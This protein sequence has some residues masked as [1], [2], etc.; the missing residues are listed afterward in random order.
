MGNDI[1]F[2]DNPPNTCIAV[3]IKTSMTYGDQI[4]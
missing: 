3:N 4:Q 2:E 1:E